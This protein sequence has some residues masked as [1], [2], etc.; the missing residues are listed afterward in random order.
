MV[1]VS[2]N[3]YFVRNMN[4]TED[5]F[6][7]V[8]V[9]VITNS[10]ESGGASSTSTSTSNVHKEV[11]I[12]ARNCQL[13]M[14]G[15]LSKEIFVTSWPNG[16]AV[17]NILLSCELKKCHVLASANVHP[18]DDAKYTIQGTKTC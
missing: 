14:A 5:R 1:R 17:A 13:L 18:S 7:I 8:P 9:T 15:N 6:T 11:Q 2:S 3:G 12:E 16:E 10:S 4:P